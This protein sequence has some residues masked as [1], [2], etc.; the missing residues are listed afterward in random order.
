MTG[1]GFKRWG[2]HSFVRDLE[3]ETKE[4]D[5]PDSLMVRLTPYEVKGLAD[6]ACYRGNKYI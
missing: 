2:K 3:R 6:Y 4:G 1:N 5:A